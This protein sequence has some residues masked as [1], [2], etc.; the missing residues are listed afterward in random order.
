MLKKELQEQLDAAN[1]L[2]QSFRS[3]SEV[4]RDLIRDAAEK[5]KEHRRLTS[6]VNDART[7][8]EAIMQ[9][10]CRDIAEWQR[11]GY[12]SVQYAKDHGEELP[13]CPPITELY[14]SLLHISGILDRRIIEEK[15]DTRFGY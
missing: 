4:N 8:I 13:V 1:K 14:S 5:A 6:H 9:I 2:I 10:N 11:H 7:A 3:E 12:P 15:K